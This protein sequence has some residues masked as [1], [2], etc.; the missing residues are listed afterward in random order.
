MVFHPKGKKLEH[1]DFLFDSNDAG[2]DDPD[3]SLIKSIE[4]ITNF[5]KIPAF[6]ML[7]VWFDANLTF[8]YHTK[9]VKSKI[10]SVLFSMR[11]AKNILSN[12]ALKTIYY[13]LVHPHLLYCLPVYSCTSSKNILMLSKKQKDCI[14]IISML[15]PSLSFLH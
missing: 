10:S 5:S 11:K 8:D 1:F 9:K 14:R 6:K 4:R 2:I 12:N 15:I 7:G 3:P 13:A